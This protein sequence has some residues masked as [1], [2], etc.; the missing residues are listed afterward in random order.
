MRLLEQQ[1][2]R[3]AC[4]PACESGCDTGQSTGNCTV[5]GVDA[6]GVGSSDPRRERGKCGAE[7]VHPRIALRHHRPRCDGVD[8]GRSGVGG[9]DDLGDPGPELPCGTQFGDRHELV[10]VCGEAEAD[11]LQ[12]VRRLDAVLGQ[13]A[14]IGD[15]GRNG[16]RELPRRAGTQIVEGRT[17][18]GDRAH[19]AVIIGDPGGGCH[20]VIHR[21]C[22][23]ARERSRQ[24][25]AAE[26]DGEPGTP[27][28]VQIG[29]QGQ[30]RIRRGGVVR[31]RV[32]DHRDELEEHPL[33]QPVQLARGDAVRP[34]PRRFA[35]PAADAQHQRAGAL[36]Q[37]VQHSP[38]AVLRILPARQRERLRH[39][40]SRLHVAHRIA[41]TDKRPAAGQRRFGL[42]VQDGV[43]RADRKALVRRRIEELLGF[44]AQV[45]GILAAALGKHA[46]H[47]RAP[48]LSIGLGNAESRTG[49]L[50]GHRQL[51]LMQRVA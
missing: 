1:Q 8:G 21:R 18:D 29:D 30:H 26:I 27:F 22:G 19:A 23:S 37:R 44:G 14:Q 17:I 36:G 9:T 24:R 47:S 28:A 34:I 7:H 2:L 33:E 48:L 16:G 51:P 45:S 6:D 12:R 4:H 43:Q 50:F 38:V 5:E 49:P 31:P 11:L 46:G 3:V 42:A 35:R 10:V 15:T 32:E 41:T 40:P 20:H 13:H 25:I 39:L